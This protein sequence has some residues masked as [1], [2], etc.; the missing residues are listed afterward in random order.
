MLLAGLINLFVPFDATTINGEP[1]T[2]V[3][4]TYIALIGAGGG[5]MVAGIPFIIV[6]CVRI[7]LKLNKE[8]SEK[9]E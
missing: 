2:T 6:G 4:N 8:K 1:I 5:V 9:K 7:G 3:R